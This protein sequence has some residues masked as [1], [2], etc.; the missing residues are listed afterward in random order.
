MWL[1][2]FIE[3]S[4][5]PICEW[6]PAQVEF[7]PSKTPP[8][9]HLSQL[10][11]WWAPSRSNPVLKWSNGCCAAAGVV[12]RSRQSKMGISVFIGFAVPLQ[13]SHLNGTDRNRSQ[14]HRCEY[15]RFDGNH[16][17]GYPA[18]FERRVTADDRFRNWRSGEHRPA[19]MMFAC[20]D[21]SATS[22]S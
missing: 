16:C 20:R 6:Q 11:V 15:R 13:T 19:G 8:E 7:V 17:S 12:S 3:E 9:W 1:A 22:T 18:S 10:T 14:T 21:Q 5:V 4:T 2:G